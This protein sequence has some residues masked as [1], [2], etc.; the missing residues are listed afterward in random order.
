MRLIALRAFLDR[1][2]LDR[3]YSQARSGFMIF[4]EGGTEEEIDS[5]AIYLSRL[6][7]DK[8]FILKQKKL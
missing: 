1:D 5:V 6:T 4:T 2:N 3:Y 8:V 7:M